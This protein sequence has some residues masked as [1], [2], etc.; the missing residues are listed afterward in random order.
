MHSWPGNEVTVNV[1]QAMFHPCYLCVISVLCS[2]VAEEYHSNLQ[3]YKKKAKEHTETHA[4][5]VTFADMAK[6]HL[7]Y[8]CSLSGNTHTYTHARMACTHTHRPCTKVSVI[9]RVHCT[10]KL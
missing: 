8:D 6:V 10:S 2:V 4:K 7:Q 1:T 9:R 3:L 5:K